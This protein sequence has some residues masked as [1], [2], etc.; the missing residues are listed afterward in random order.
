MTGYWGATGQKTRL[1]IQVTSTIEPDGPRSGRNWGMATI[2]DGLC[3][4]TVT[5]RL[6]SIQYSSGTIFA[7][8][9]GRSWVP[10]DD[11][12]KRGVNRRPG[13]QIDL[14]ITNVLQEVSYITITAR[15]TAFFGAGYSEGQI[16]L[17]QL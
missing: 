6:G 4:M 7:L 14:T 2:R 17:S 9:A 12:R 1:R 5:Q 11:E 15:I 3:H 13:I 8:F 16:Y 10:T